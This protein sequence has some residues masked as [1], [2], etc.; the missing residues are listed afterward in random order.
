MQE[1]MMNR[2]DALRSCLD[3]LEFHIQKEHAE[4]AVSFAALA[5]G[6]AERITD[7][8]NIIAAE[9]VKHARADS[10]SWN[11][12]AIEFGITRQGA[13]QRWRDDVY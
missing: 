4:S 13:Q 1:N 2:V 12:I 10:V 7:Q 8:T 9:A 11:D 3:D 6:I 5:A